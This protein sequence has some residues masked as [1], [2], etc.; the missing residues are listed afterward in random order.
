MMAKLFIL[1]PSARI[2]NYIPPKQHL[3]A[4]T[5]YGHGRMVNYVQIP[6]NNLYWNYTECRFY[7]GRLEPKSS[8]NLFLKW[9]ILDESVPAGKPVGKAG[10]NRETNSPVPVKTVLLFLPGGDFL[11]SP[12]AMIFFRSGFFLE[13]NLSANS[14]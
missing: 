13:E 6:L 3:Q 14:K 7:Q 8:K 11:F 1:W 10:W 12:Q 9:T 2:A 5:S 4:A